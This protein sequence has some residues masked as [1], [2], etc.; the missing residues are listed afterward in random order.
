[1]N[2]QELI[3]L[4]SAINLYIEKYGNSH[5]TKDLETKLTNQLMK[6]LTIKK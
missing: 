2:T 4:N 5:N 3:I 6:S 1:M